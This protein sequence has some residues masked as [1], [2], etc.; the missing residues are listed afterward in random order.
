MLNQFKNFVSDRLDIDELIEL[1]AFGKMLRA[2]YEAH[3]LEEP[4]FVDSQLKALKRE[5]FARNADRLEARKREIRSRLDSL[6]TPTQRKS[7]LEKELR[8]IDK[9]LQPA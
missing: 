4:E 1:T 3:Q 2:E 6:K 8:E 5:I 9:Q 7:E